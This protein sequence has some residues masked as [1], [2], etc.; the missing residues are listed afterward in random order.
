MPFG[1]MRADARRN[2]LSASRRF[3][4]W[5][6]QSAAWIFFPF[7]AALTLAGCTDAS[8]STVEAVRIAMH[9]TATEPTAASV[10][11]LPYYQLEVISSA[12]NGVLVLGNVDG[13]REIWYGR[14]GQALCLEHGRLVQTMGLAQNLDGARV[15]GQDPFAAGLQRLDAP[16]HYRR[17]ED[18]SPGY[19]Y[20]VHVDATLVPNGETD[21]DILGMRRHVRLVTEAI[22]APTAQYWATNRYWVD[23][24]DG[25]IWM[26]EQQVLPGLAVK[27]V[28]LRPYRGKH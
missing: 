11:A 28:Q 19:R 24:D 1:T 26:S 14:P 2:A 7:L 16:L 20:G 23:P 8:R 13:V 9:R 6:G 27:L 18:W 17:V 4:R 5:P 15:E 12:G 3:R 21:I 22:S 25:F 10:A